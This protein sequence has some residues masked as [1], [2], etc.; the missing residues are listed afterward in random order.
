MDFKEALKAAADE[1]VAKQHHSADHLIRQAFFE[2]VQFYMQY[3]QKKTTPP[4]P[5]SV[6]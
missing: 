2:G 1:C 3:V 4:D 5:T 6:L